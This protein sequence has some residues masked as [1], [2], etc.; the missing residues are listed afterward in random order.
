DADG[1]RR[2]LD[3]HGLEAAYSLALPVDRRLPEYPDRAEAFLKRAV[4]RVA[5]AGGTFLS[6]VLYGT[7]GELSGHRPRDDEYE[8]IA[9]TLR[10]VAR[11][12]ADHGVSLGLGPVNR[13]ETYLVNTVDQALRLIE[14]IGEPNVFVHLDTYHANI[15]ENGFVAPI[16]KAGRRLRYLHLSESHRGVPGTGT[17]LWDDVFRALKA[18]EFQ[19]DLVMESFVAVHPD[20]ARATCLWR[21]VAPSSEVLVRDG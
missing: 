12:A 9:T 20:I 5:A 10:S 8:T 14:A 21:D 17:V 11:Y 4:H 15:E 1:F 19:G 18:I 7:L 16:E 3:Q 2:I 6:G 13:Y